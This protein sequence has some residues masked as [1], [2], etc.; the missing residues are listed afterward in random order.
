MIGKQTLY[1]D[2]SDQSLPFRQRRYFSYLCG[3]NEPDCH[4]T[5]D[6]AK[7]LLILYVPDFDLHRA[8]WNGPTLT[9][10][11]ARNRYI[12]P[13][14]KKQSKAWYADGFDV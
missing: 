7:D 12:Y 2:D 4:L 1:L 3:A 10:E 11:E 9:A 13:W 5:Y 14:I 6:I 8:V